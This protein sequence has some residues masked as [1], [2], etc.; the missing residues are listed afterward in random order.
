MEPIS[1]VEIEPVDHAFDVIDFTNVS[2][3]ERLV[4]KLQ[5]IILN[6]S[7]NCNDEIQVEITSD[8]SSGEW[9]ERTEVFTF[10]SKEITAQ[11]FFLK[12]S[13][14]CMDRSAT[15]NHRD[16]LASTLNQFNDFPLHAPPL[17]HW[18]GLCEFMIITSDDAERTMSAV[19]VALLNTKCAVATFVQTYT[20]VDCM[21]GMC[22][23]NGFRT[24]FNIRHIGPQTHEPPS[25]AELARI[26]EQ[27]LD[28]ARDPN[29]VYTVASRL[30]FER[31]NL[32]ADWYSLYPLAAA[33]GKQPSRYA[34]ALVN[35]PSVNDVL[36][37]TKSHSLFPI[38]I[39]RESIK[40]IRLQI[41]MPYFTNHYDVVSENVNP[42]QAQE[43]VISI[44]RSANLQENLCSR[45]FFKK[46]IEII[47]SD[48]S[49]EIEN[50]DD[51]SKRTSIA[52]LAMDYGQTGIRAVSNTSFHIVKRFANKV[53]QKAWNFISKRPAYYESEVESLVN[54]L[55]S[56]PVNS[57]SLNGTEFKSAPANSFCY[58]LAILVTHLLNEVD[59]VSQASQLLTIMCNAILNGLEYYIGSQTEIYSVKGEPSDQFCSFYQL[60]QLANYCIRSWNRRDEVGISEMLMDKAT[61][62]DSIHGEASGRANKFGDEKSTF[63]GAQ[64]YIPKLKDS[65]IITPDI[66]QILLSSN[67]ESDSLFVEI[68]KSD[69][70]AFKAANPWSSIYDFIRWYSPRDAFLN[71]DGY[72]ELSERMS[73]PGNI[74]ETTW[75]DADAVSAEEQSRFLDFLQGPNTVGIVKSYHSTNPNSF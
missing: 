30:N 70:E 37:K 32:S 72:W 40:S 52:S 42:S 44:E 41:K 8:F 39:S 15:Y 65:S 24:T 73:T 16:S 71:Q 48:Y 51:S 28:V 62:F 45:M 17:A 46:L 2:D 7:L 60:L 74:W 4:A 59:F 13:S 34:S 64:L 3:F 50:V 56:I 29:A 22:L 5:E 1:L 14:N 23:N 10:M 55:F 35:V 19:S 6:W 20:M 68:L 26:F 25:F 63:D 36:T 61:I 49:K 54:G 27:K 69:M 38:G 33:L 18:F 11:H 53:G 58:N 43:W 12:K 75:D 9:H 47:N 57:K 21:A 66:H 31:D 67:F